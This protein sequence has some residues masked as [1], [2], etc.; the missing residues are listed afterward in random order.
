[1]KKIILGLLSMVL[2]V[3]CTDLSNTPTKKV[4][5]FLKKYQALDHNVLT[6]LDGVIAAEGIFNENQKKEYRD[7]MKKHYQNLTYDIKGE[8]IDGDNAV[9]TV[10]ITVTD[11]KKILEE[12]NRYRDEHPEEFQDESGVRDASKFIDYR[13]KKMKEAKDSITYTLYI[14][15]TKTNDTW[16]LDKLDNT[17]YDKINGVYNY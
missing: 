10:E 9:V 3:G 8:T 1:M 6:D 11:F 5:A 15:L 2:L 14:S 17:T 13:L 16:N 12:A 4:E 7:I